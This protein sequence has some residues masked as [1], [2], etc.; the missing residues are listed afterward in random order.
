M[1]EIEINY[2]H[3]INKVE[4]DHLQEWFI[5]WQIMNEYRLITSDIVLAER[6]L[7][8]R[9]Y[10]IEIG[11]DE[12]IRFYLALKCN[13]IIIEKK[14]TNEKNIDFQSYNIFMKFLFKIKKLT[15]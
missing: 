9:I 15:M 7:R 12:D 13:N 4:L 8:N 2:Y 10:S 11:V 3:G 5:K 6:K 14:Y 1:K